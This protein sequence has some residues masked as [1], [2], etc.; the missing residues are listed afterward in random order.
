M[1]S[2]RPTPITVNVPVGYPTAV[3]FLDESGSKASASGL[4]VIGAVK[5][6]QPGAFLRVVRDVR[7]RTGFGN[8][9]FKF[10]DINRGSFSAYCELIDRLAESEAH[11][12][13]CVV[14]AEQYN[15]FTHGKAAWQVHAKVASQLLMGCINRRELVTVLMDG[16]STPVGCSLEDDVRKIVNRRFKATSIVGAVC[17]DS[18]SNDG[19]QV[20]DLVASA[21]AFERRLAKGAGGKASS[22]KARVA[23]RLRFAMDLVDFNDQRSER[24]NILTLRGPAATVRSLSVVNLHRPTG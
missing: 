14:D 19:L 13:A 8:S 21:I 22:P 7:D 4:F 23:A 16:I 1:P 24:V 11:L 10:S 9:E 2:N 20:A 15:P 5:V 3:L 18:R 17:L 6:R 12:A